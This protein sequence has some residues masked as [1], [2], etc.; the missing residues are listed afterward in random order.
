MEQIQRASKPAVVLLSG[1]LDSATATA[2]ARAEGY[3]IFA[4][5]IDYGQRHRWELQA[6]QKVARSLG[7]SKH[8][9]VS[10]GLAQI[11]GSALTSD[12]AVPQDRTDVEMSSG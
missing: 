10:V 11:G 12:I 9:T 6:A 3:E 2:I 7:V 5:S 1:G 4:L 8:V